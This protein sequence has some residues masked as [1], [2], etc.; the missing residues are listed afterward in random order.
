MLNFKNIALRRGARVLFA[1]ASFTIHKAQKVGFTGANGAGKSSF[2][3]LIRNE[4]HVDEGDFSLPPGLEI[5]H[6]LQETPAVTSSA[7]DYVMDGDRE[8][9][10]LQQQLT[11]AETAHRAH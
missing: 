3:A 11:V 4:L 8:F 6:V 9:R 10:R 1:D 5:A 2:F 7:I